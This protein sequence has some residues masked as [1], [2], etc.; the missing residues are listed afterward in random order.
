[1]PP[2]FEKFTDIKW[3][4][5]DNARKIR[6]LLIGLVTLN[7]RLHIDGLPSGASDKETTSQCRTCKRHRIVPGSGRS[8]GEGNGTPSQYSCLKNPMDRGAWRATVHVIIKSQIWL[9]NVACKHIHRQW[10]DWKV[11]L[12][13]SSGKGIR[14]I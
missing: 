3:S 5:L 14:E 7:H 8:P 12:I 4:F 11:I 1:M 10:S 6:C 2:L 13:S 9:S